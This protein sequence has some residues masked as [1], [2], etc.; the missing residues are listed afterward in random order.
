[1]ASLILLDA[2]WDPS[3]VIIFIT[4]FSTIAFLVWTVFSTIRRAQIAKIQAGVQSKLLDKF[5]SGQELANLLQTEQ[6]KKLLD[7]LAV[8]EQVKPYGRILAAAQ[9]GVILALA[10]AALLLLRKYVSGAYEVLLVVGA[11]A[12]AM[13]IGFIVSAAIS[14]RL[15]KSLG[16]L[17]GNSGPKQR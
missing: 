9:V 13:G 14:Y 5:S 1:M 16:L 17:N 4:L 2:S 12:L 7:S 10:G 11:L 8:T 3:D 15:S 6:G